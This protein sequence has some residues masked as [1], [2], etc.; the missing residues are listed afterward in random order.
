MQPESETGPQGVDY[1]TSLI[2]AIDMTSSKKA[3]RRRFEP[4]CLITLACLTLVI[5][6][7]VIVY[8]LTQSMNVPH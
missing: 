5:I 4:S 2:Q 8:T 7:A 3:L 6:A 1:A